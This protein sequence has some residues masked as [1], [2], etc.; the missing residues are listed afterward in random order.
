MSCGASRWAPHGRL[1]ALCLRPPFQTRSHYCVC[2]SRGTAHQ[3]SRRYARALQQHQQDGP[4]AQAADGPATN[5]GAAAADGG[6]ADGEAAAFP[7]PPALLL[8]VPGL[9]LWHKLDSS[10]KQPR[11]NAYLRLFS[12]AG[13]AS[14][15]AAALSHLLVR[16][17]AGWLAGWEALPLSTNQPAE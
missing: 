15:R 16:G 7:S 4:A 13:Y 5:G 9:R 1:C 6:A 10:F 3:P 12:E 2:A 14:P 11:T 17:P 8:D